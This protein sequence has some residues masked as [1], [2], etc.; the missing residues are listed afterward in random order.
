[1]SC[2]CNKPFNKV[3]LDKGWYKT[4]KIYCSCCGE[5]A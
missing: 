1:M 4:K 3:T 2:K 5:K